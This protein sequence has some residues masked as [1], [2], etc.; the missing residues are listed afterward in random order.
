MA[1]DQLPPNPPI[2]RVITGH[3]ANRKAIVTIDDFASN[4][5]WSAHGGNVSTLI[6]YADEMP[7]EIWSD[8]DYGQRIVDRQPVPRGTRICM[9]DFYPGN[10]PMMHR[11]DTLDYVICM[12]GEIDMELDDGAMVHMNAEHQIVHALQHYR[13]TFAYFDGHPAGFKST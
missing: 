3:Y 10:P 12:S 13:R 11:T 8:E 2:R 9:I 4:H 7:I 6:W 5:K 1:V